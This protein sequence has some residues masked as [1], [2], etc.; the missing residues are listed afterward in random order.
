MSPYSGFMSCTEVTPSDA[1]CASARRAARR[2]CSWLNGG[3]IRVTNDSAAS[4]NRPFGSPEAS[5][6]IAP[7]GGSGVLA[8]TPASRVAAELASAMWPS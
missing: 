2:R 3:M 6:T 1:A 4:L 8:V 7:P 5:W